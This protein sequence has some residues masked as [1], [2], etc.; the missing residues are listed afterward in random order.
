MAIGRDAMTKEVSDRRK[1]VMKIKNL[2]GSSAAK[3]RMSPMKMPASAPMTTSDMESSP[4]AM[5]K[6]GRVAKKGKGAAMKKGGIAKKPGMM[7]M[8]AIGKGKK[9]K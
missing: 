8:I 3:G 6:G 1:R 4:A 7:V 5:K 9:G 2:M